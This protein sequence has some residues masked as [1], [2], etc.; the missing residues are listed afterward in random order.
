MSRITAPVADF[1]R[2]CFIPKGAIFYNPR[3]S[4]AFENLM[5]IKQPNAVDRP[6]RNLLMATSAVGGASAIAAAVPF[7]A[8]MAPADRAIA[9]GEPVEVEL[10]DIEP[11]GIKRVEY[12]KKVVWIVRRT[13]E[14]LQSL[15]RTNPLVSDPD[16]ERSVQPSYCKN[17]YRSFKKEYLVLE[18]ICTH[19]GCS[20]AARFE[21]GVDPASGG[22]SDWAGGFYCPC[23]GSLFDLAGRVYKDKPAPDNLRVPPHRYVSDTRLLIGEH[24][25]A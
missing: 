9:A 16:S 22:G 5:A 10:G 8:S 7:A 6:R 24:Q 14:M 2:M 19:L 1:K 15:E 4:Q 21:S 20:P 23:H 25:E 3:S 18:G 13:E 11:G 12:R 17:S